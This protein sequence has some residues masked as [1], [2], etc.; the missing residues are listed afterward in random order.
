V[1]RALRI[2]ALPDGWRASFQAI[3][4]Q[5][6]AAGGAAGNAGLAAVRPSPAWPGFRPLA[7]P[8]AGTATPRRTAPRP[9][10]GHHAAGSR[11]PGGRICEGPLG[12]LTAHDVLL[13]AGQPAHLI[14]AA[15]LVAMGRWGWLLVPP[16][17]AVRDGA[18]RGGAIAGD[19]ADRMILDRLAHGEAGDVRPAH[20][21]G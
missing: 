2:V 19:N 7:A 4:S 6:E 8:P 3:L 5:P 9:G 21:R 1:Q 20:G 13:P 12:A 17:P 10:C 15:T 14:T 18:D 16:T 11:I